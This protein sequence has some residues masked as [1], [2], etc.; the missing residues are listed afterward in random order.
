MDQK[1]KDSNLMVVLD[2]GNRVDTFE[3]HTV[4]EQQAVLA[5]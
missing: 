3:G 1:T 5:S 2:G 4:E